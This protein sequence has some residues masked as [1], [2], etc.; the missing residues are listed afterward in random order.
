MARFVGHMLQ[1]GVVFLSEDGMCGGI[2]NPM[3]FNPAHMVAVEL[4]W[5]APSNGGPLRQ[6]FED[7]AKDRGASA[8]Q[9]SGLANDRL[10]AVTRIYRRGGYQPVEMSFLKRL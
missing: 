8:I 10:E 2:L 3:Y 1:N 5:W 7:W 9:F 6:A 4:F